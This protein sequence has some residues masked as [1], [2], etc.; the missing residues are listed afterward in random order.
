MNTSTLKRLAALQNRADEKRAQFNQRQM[1][2]ARKA[3]EALGNSRQAS[4]VAFSKRW[5]E[6]QNRNDSRR[7]ALKMA[8]LR[9]VVGRYEPRP[10]EIDRGRQ[11]LNLGDRE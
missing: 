4:R 9:V 7:R 5:A 8:E 3:V 10:D 11:C 2:A 6:V 1:V